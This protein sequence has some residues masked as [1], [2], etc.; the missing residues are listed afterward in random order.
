MAEVEKTLN[1]QATA[2]QDHFEVL[3]GLRGIAIFLVVWFHIWQQSWLGTSF[4]IL[5]HTIDLNFLPR[6]GF[7]GVDLFIILGAFGL[8]YPF[9]RKKF[10]GKEIRSL[11]EFTYRRCIRI[12]PSYYL[13]IILMV[14]LAQGTVAIEGKDLWHIGRHFLFINNLYHDTL[15]GSFNSVAWYV[16][17]AVQFYLLF[18]LL[19]WL[20][21]RWPIF[22]YI[23][24]TAT[25][26]IYRYWVIEYKHDQLSFLFNQVPG[27]IDIY[28]NGMLAAFLVCFIKNRVK[29]IDRLKV[30]S[31][32]LAIISFLIFLELMKYLDRN[33]YNG[34]QDFQLLTRPYFGLAFMCLVIFSVFSF[35]YWKIL[36]A[37][38]VTVFLSVISFNL[39]LWHQFIAV[40]FRLRE[41][42]PWNGNDPHN[43]PHWQ[44]FYTLAV[45]AVSVIVATLITYLFE[46]PI[47]RNGLRGTATMILTSPIKMLKCRTNINEKKKG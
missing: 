2:S 46:R 26:I 45:V 4:K 28:A 33:R 6:V 27:Y 36:L 39:F 30:F 20:F 41:I 15:F 7:I 5:G 34:L 47:E 10:E 31:T 19:C 40:Q 25:G 24:M 18:P 43:D 14:L 38:K 3:D 35:K 13:S 12:I 21:Y 44:L 8:F 32:L 29:G 11:K 1:K 42:I 22:T 17:L 16:A 23:G 9:A 37:N